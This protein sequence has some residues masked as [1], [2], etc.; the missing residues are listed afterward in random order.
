[1]LN[2]RKQKIKPILW[3]FKEQHKQVLIKKVSETVITILMLIIYYGNV[4]LLLEVG[5][6]ASPVAQW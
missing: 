3:L 6:Q 1:M 5:V 2:D 4:L